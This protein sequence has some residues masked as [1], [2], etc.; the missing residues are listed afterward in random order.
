[1]TVGTYDRLEDCETVLPVLLLT[2]G[3]TGER[4]LSVSA[5][6]KV[7]V[8]ALLVLMDAFEEL[9][10]SD[11]LDVDEVRN[12]DETVRDSAVVDAI[13]IDIGCSEDNDNGVVVGI[14]GREDLDLLV[15]TLEDEKVLVVA[16]LT[17]T[18]ADGEGS[19]IPELSLTTLEVVLG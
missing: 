15:D 8:S 4:T 16:V 17:S 13:E 19:T 7:D 12:E 18:T 1:M 2:D 9:V 14:D 5:V 11:L 3:P 6:D 10:I